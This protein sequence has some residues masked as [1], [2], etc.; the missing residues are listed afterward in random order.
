[1]PHLLQLPQGQRH[2]RHE[3][4]HDPDLAHR[5]RDP[6][7]ADRSL[8]RPARAGRLELVRLLPAG[9][10]GR[11]LVEL[12]VLDRQHR[13]RQPG[14]QPADA[15]GRPELQHGQRRPGRRSAAPAPS[16]NAPAPWV[17]YTRAGCDV[18]NVGVANTVLENNTAIV[19]P[20][21]A[22]TTTLAAAVG[23]R[24]TRTSRSR[25]RRRPRAAA[26]RSCSRTG[27][28]SRGRDDRDVGIA[29]ATARASTST[30]P[31]AKAHT[32]GG[33][34]TVYA[35]DP[36][37]DMT[38]VFG[39]GS[40]EWIEGRDSQIA[41]SGTAAR[42]LAQTDFVG[43]RDPLR[44]AGGGDLQPERRERASP[45]RCPT[46]PAATRASGPVRGEVREPGDQ[47]RQRVRQ[48]HR[49]GSRSQDPVRPVRLPGLRRHV[50][51]EH[52]R[53][54]RAD[55]GGR[56]P[57]HVRLHLRRPRRPRRR[58]RDPPRLR[59]GRGR[60]RP[61]AQGLRPGVRATSSPA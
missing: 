15:V 31:L 21:R 61:A 49:T 7:L 23:R 46:R 48:R 18:G 60:L 42:N 11:L 54:G 32:S 9:R 40:P 38:K 43:I 5:R 10:L 57:G 4:P 1:M 52:A 51:P 25:Q 30:A 27:R 17:P 41:P 50:R 55:A 53:R 6:E 13:R 58:R 14:E 24:A 26:R 35:A 16:R 28:A 36:T 29:G 47:Q 37:G 44:D 33:A 20:R 12:Q 19:I 59:A 8:S 34:V 3:R 45:T 22:G 56:R 2:V 39:A